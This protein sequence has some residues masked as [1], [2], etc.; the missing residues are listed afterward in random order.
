MT[1]R[2]LTD[3]EVMELVN[4]ACEQRGWPIM[5]LATCRVLGAFEQDGHLVEFLAIQLFPILGPMA[6]VDNEAR[7]DGSVSRELSR[8]MEQF[9]HDND[10][11]GWM[12]VADNPFVERL[13]ERHGMKRVQSPVFMA[14]SSER[15]N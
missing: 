7:D 6:R 14:G 8:R 1:Y 9:L 10:A 3:E 12:A 11:R 4:P 15:V 2:F 13:C 5:N